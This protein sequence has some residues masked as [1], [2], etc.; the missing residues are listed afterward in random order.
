MSSPEESSF[1]THLRIKRPEDAQHE[2]WVLGQTD[3]YAA[4]VGYI[5][6]FIEQRAQMGDMDTVEVLK[7]FEE[8]VCRF[9]RGGYDVLGEQ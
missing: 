1:K 9:M 4:A 3:T 8:N 7:E 5:S 2:A 6:F